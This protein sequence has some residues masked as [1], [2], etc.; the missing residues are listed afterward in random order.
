M[1][2]LTLPEPGRL[3]PP[4]RLAAGLG[5]RGLLAPW[6]RSSTSAAPAELASAVAPGLRVLAGVAA[7]EPT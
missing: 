6:S 7:V 4:S 1:S 2:P 5:A 3:W